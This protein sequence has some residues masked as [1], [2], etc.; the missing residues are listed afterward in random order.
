MVPVSMTFSEPD[1]NFMVAVFFEIIC[2]NSARWS[3]SC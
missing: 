2:Q 3:H 1:P